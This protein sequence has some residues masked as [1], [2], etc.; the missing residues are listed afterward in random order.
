MREALTDLIETWREGHGLL[1]EELIH[2]AVRPLID[3]EVA[4]YASMGVRRDDIAK[5]AW[6]LIVQALREY[7]TD[8]EVN[9][10]G[11]L[12]TRLTELGAKVADLRQAAM[13][14]RATPQAM[15]A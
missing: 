5:A 11:Y 3:L 6:E 9:V 2:S 13:Q 12:T 7:N 4:R 1:H 10:V 8:G 14:L 15:K